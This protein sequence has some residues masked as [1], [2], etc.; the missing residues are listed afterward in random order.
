MHGTGIRAVARTS[1]HFC[2]VFGRSAMER[3]VPVHLLQVVDLPDRPGR[4]FRE[5]LD[6]DGRAGAGNPALVGHDVAAV[7]AGQ[8]VVHERCVVR[9]QTWSGPSWNGSA[10]GR[11][12]PP[13]RRRKALNLSISPQRPRLPCA[14]KR[15]CFTVSSAFH[16]TLI[17][18]N[19]I[20]RRIGKHR[21]YGPFC[22]FPSCRP[23][24][25][26]QISRPLVFSSSFCY[27][28]CC[29]ACLNNGMRHIGNR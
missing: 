26:S 24:E 6:A 22:E 15:G 9:R 20:S 13:I 27:V 2:C 25:L 21:F 11:S 23:S 12:R 16:P 8:S 1:S 19:S 4:G 28:S 14:S 18:H 5:A 17:N 7:Q 3:S 10:S 29:R